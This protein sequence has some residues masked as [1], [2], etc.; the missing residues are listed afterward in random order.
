MQTKKSGKIKNKILKGVPTSAAVSLLL[1]GII[2]A[3]VFNLDPL[4]FNRLI[5]REEAVEAKGVFESYEFLYSGKTDSVTEVRIY[6][7][8]R[9]ELY[10]NNYNYDM[11]EKLA[12]L[13]R[14]DEVQ[15][16]LHPNSDCIWEILANGNVLVAFDE[17]REIAAVDN[18][19]S[20]AILGGF[21][22][23]CAVIGAASLI[24]KLFE[25]RRIK[26]KS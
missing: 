23:V 13:R 21:G 17:V 24:S 3:V 25:R 14:G 6:F 20:G 26:K 10:L 16:L 22:L 8:D 9:E 12:L 5:E 4:Y 18:I 1:M 15:L 2:I 7:S 11:D 19:L